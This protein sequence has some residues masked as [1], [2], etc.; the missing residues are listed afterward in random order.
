MVVK[1][2]VVRWV[3]A[4]ALNENFFS[5]LSYRQV[6]VQQTIENNLKIL[7]LFKFPVFSLD[8]PRQKDS[9]VRRFWRRPTFSLSYTDL[10]F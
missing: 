7:F 2:L 3:C 5:F 6:F 10:R 8:Q 9:F 1:K 4:L